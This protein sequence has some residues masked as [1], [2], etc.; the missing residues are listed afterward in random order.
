MVKGT[1]A[2][3][4]SEET[5]SPDEPKKEDTPSPAA[6]PDEILEDEADK[7]LNHKITTRSRA[8][9]MPKK[10]KKPRKVI[11]VEKKPVDPLMAYQ[12]PFRGKG[13]KQEKPADAEKPKRVYTLE[14]IF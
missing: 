1:N 6:T 5:K 14:F 4:A 7:R 3:L 12:P 10:E 13:E 2:P 9:D 11:V 8:E